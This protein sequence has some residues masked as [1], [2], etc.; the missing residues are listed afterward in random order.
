MTND[1]RELLTLAAKA[2]GYEILEHENDPAFAR[3]ETRPPGWKPYRND[4]FSAPQWMERIT[5]WNPLEHDGDAFALMVDC[6]LSTFPGHDDVA[7][8]LPE[9]DITCYE[10]L[11]NHPDRAAATRR[12]IVKAAAELGRQ[13]E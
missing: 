8:Y 3:R 12:A 10:L 2:A 11:K 7:V 13:K 6:G 5:I 9:T 4:E 1:D